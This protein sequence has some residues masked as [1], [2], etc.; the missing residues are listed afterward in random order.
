MLNHSK[1]LQVHSMI[2]IIIESEDP[3]GK[4]VYQM[5][6]DNQLICKFGHH[7]PDGLAKCL[8]KAADAVE[9]SDWAKNV[10]RT[11]AKGG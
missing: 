2:S 11:D 9:L 10:L 4:S 7:S 3:G 1:F 6:F 8:R 5:M